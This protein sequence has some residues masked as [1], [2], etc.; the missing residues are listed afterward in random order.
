MPTWTILATAVAAILLKRPVKFVADR[1]SPPATSHAREHHIRRIAANA[2]GDI[3][4]FE[5]DDPS[6]GPFA[7]APAVSEVKQ[8]TRSWKTSRGAPAGHL[9]TVAQPR[10]Q[11]LTCWYRGGPATPCGLRRDRIVGPGGRQTESTDLPPFASC[12]VMLT[13]RCPPPAPGHRLKRPHEAPLPHEALTGPTALAVQASYRAWHHCG[14]LVADR[15]DQPRLEQR[16]GGA[17]RSRTQAIRPVEFSGAVTVMA[18]A[19]AS[20][21]R[22]ICSIFFTHDHADATAR[23]GRSASSPQAVQTRPA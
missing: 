19:S 21:A 16:R 7:S 4:A 13:T 1:L 17:F 23:R 12:T 9:P 10:V 20:R 18:S 3:L 11:S 14:A 8:Q 22:A 6:D 5:I 2:Q 15:A